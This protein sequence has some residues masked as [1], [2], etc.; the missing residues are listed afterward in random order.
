MPFGSSDKLTAVTLR[1]IS[2]FNRT[3]VPGLTIRACRHTDRACEPG[4][5]Q[6]DGDGRARLSVPQTTLAPGLFY[7]HRYF[8]L[9]S[10]SGQ[11]E[12]V[13][14]G[15]PFAS[16]KAA[17]ELMWLPAFELPGLM[18]EGRGILA[19]LLADCTGS[20]DDFAR[21]PSATAEIVGGPEPFYVQVSD[22]S[23]RHGRGPFA[24]F[25]PVLPGEHEIVIHDPDQRQVHKTNALVE[26]GAYTLLHV[27]VPFIQ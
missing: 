6:T 13:Y 4:T 17:V 3:G 15:R 19:V 23:V 1:I 22:P 10:A 25:A 20:F 14:A 8:E 24:V 7:G 2:G 9:S 11:R 26:A 12:L 5:A 18:Q 16:D 21:N 27:T